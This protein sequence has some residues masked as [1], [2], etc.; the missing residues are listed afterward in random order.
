[1]T[2]QDFLKSKIDIA[3]EV[4]FDISPE[5]INPALKPHQRDA[6]R[7]AVKMGR[8][9]LFEKFGLGKTVQELEWCRLTAE[10]A[11]GRALIVLPLGVKQEFA[12]DSVRVLGWDAPPP[13]VRNAAEIAATGA[14][15]V[16]T[17]YERLRD[18][19]IDVSAFQAVALDEA[20]VLRGFGSTKTFRE[21]MRKLAAVPYKLV[22][23]ATPSPNEFKEILAYAAYLGIMDV[24]MGKTK[25]FKRDSTQANHLTLYPA[26]EKEFW[27]WV[28][29]WALVLTK[30][31]DL[32][33]D[34]AGY[35]LPPMEVR[36]HKVS[37]TE[38]PQEFTHFGQAKLLRN[39]AISLVDASRE[40]H[41]SIRERVAKAKEIVDSD[42]EAH[43]ILWHD[44][45]A[46]RHAI[47]R[48]V[49]E[50]VE[51]YGTQDIDT[52]EQRTIDFADGKY[53][54]LAT[55][56]EISGEGTNFQ[57]HCHRAI[58]VGIDYRFND[59]IQAVHRIYR[60]LQGETVIIDIIYTDSEDAIRDALIE[61]WKRH[62][63]MT[64]KMVEIVQ[65]NGLSTGALARGLNRKLGVKRMIETGEDYVAI[66]NDCVEETQR[67]KDNSVGLIVT[68]IPFGNHYEYSANYNDF[69]HNESNDKF[70]EQMDFLTPE[71][72]R[73]LQPGRILCVHVKDRIMFGNTSGYG[74]P[75]S[76]AFHA[77]CIMHYRKHGFRY[78]NM[79]TVVTDVV[80]ENAQTYRL[81]W[82]EQCKDGSKMGVGCPEYVLIFRKQQTDGDK[83]YADKPV[84]K[85]K[86]DYSRARWQIDAH[87]HWRSSG[88]RPVRR[89]EI[90]S[91]DYE[92]CQK[93]FRAYS[94]QQPYDYADHV[95]IA[96]ELDKIGL[97]PP[98]FQT[99]A[100]GSWSADV[101]DDIT[102]VKTLNSRQTQRKLEN[103]I[104]PLQIDIVE[105]L[106]NRFSNPGDVVYDPFAG[107]FTVPWCALRMDR[108]G[109]GCE[110]S[111]DYFRDG[112]SYLRAEE[113]KRNMP[114]LFDLLPEMA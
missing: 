69:G 40:K 1:M 22:A 108:K 24:G 84:T 48:A 62:D 12:R 110:L 47:T 52:R 73:V 16:M 55:K 98:S 81:G 102:R 20:S 89:E 54:I 14:R 65:K 3:P 25:F 6:T 57:R 61:K 101:W 43:F 68:S 105:R 32:G 38:R 85:N 75:T 56:K 106:I 91:S 46:E 88:D 104:C 76:D 90:L 72:L 103:H 59:F 29:S 82:T 107:L 74:F 86:A 31:S 35:A 13:Y 50:A 97:L 66:N 30:P 26:R 8:C 64:E 4:G 21:F 18:G 80:R 27:A 44:R 5:E 33:Y 10:K 39:V 114:T 93:L 67:M 2:Y 79:I 94:N 49:P 11:G 113:A 87:A 34:D 23:T 45:E 96:E 100:V 28:S 42:P 92:T 19:D 37:L 95:A 111:A 17:N 112:V 71:L 78:M 99:C 70:F 60:F 63:E 15:I 9:A 41:D 7:W 109:I 51:I 77:E 58:F 83:G 36:W 53:R